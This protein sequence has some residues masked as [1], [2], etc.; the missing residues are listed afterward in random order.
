MS[1]SVRRTASLLRVPTAT[2]I[3]PAGMGTGGTFTLTEKLS[4]LRT[5]SGVVPSVTVRLAGP[6]SSPKVP[7]SDHL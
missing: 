3:A 6:G 2:C 7:S 5:S 4:H 1:H